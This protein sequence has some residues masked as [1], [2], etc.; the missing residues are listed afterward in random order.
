MAFKFRSLATSNG[1]ICNGRYLRSLKQWKNKKCKNI[2][3]ELE[4]KNNKK[5]RGSRQWKKLTQARSKLLTKV[6]NKIN[7]ILHKYTTGLV[8]TQ[9]LMGVNTLIVGDLKGYR[10]ENNSGKVRNQEN[11]EWSYSKITQMLKY[12]CEKYGLKFVLQEESYTSKTC[13]QCGNQKKMKGR[14]FICKNC[15]FIGH[16]DVVG[17]YNIL[18]KYL[19]IFNNF[20]VVPEIA[21]GFSVRYKS[22]INVTCG[23]KNLKLQEFTGF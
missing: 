23:F 18:K 15:S 3:I 13:P 14:E 9:K 10:L 4:S 2:Q 17:A 1:V 11:H 6:N 22:N 21:P 19:G 16:R 12:K 8:L 20:Q 5:K 7:D